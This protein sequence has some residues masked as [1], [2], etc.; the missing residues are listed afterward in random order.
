VNQSVPGEA[1]GRRGFQLRLDVVDLV[2]NLGRKGQTHDHR[3]AI[4][5]GRVFLDGALDLVLVKS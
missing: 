4:A 3:Q 1:T 2:S 5:G